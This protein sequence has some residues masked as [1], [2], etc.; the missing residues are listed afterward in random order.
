MTY[1]IKESLVYLK[2]V[3]CFFVSHPFCLNIF[4]LGYQIRPHYFHNARV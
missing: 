2:A 1:T 3:K 4:I